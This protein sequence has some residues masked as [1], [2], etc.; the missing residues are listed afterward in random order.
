MAINFT[1]NPEYDFLAGMIPHH[2]AASSMCEVYQN[3]TS[4]G[5]LASSLQRRHEGIC[6]GS[7]SLC[8]NITYG[9]TKWGRYQS[10]FSQRNETEQMLAVLKELGMLDHY[11]SGCGVQTHADSGMFM[12]CGQLQS[13]MAKEYLKLNMWMHTKMS[14]N[15]SGNQAVDFLKGMIPHHEAAVEMCAIYYKYWT[16]KHTQPPTVCR[17]PMASELVANLINQNRFSELDVLNYM[18][19]I[20]T[21]HILVSQ[22]PE[23][24]WMRQELRRIDSDQFAML[25]LERPCSSSS[26]N[27]ADDHSN[28]SHA[29]HDQNG[30]KETANNS[31]HAHSGHTSSIADGGNRSVA[32]SGCMRF[33]S[34]A[35][36]LVALARYAAVWANT[37]WV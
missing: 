20:C 7:A 12:G 30:T 22:P 18:H 23:I 32:V 19:H 31:S 6:C 3:A 11:R 26:S 35:T 13:S 27:Q 36:M 14:L 9:P 21:E 5:S 4:A 15:Y 29:G 10:D 17:N 28:V 24:Q 25:E 16:C 34:R 8:Y 2:Q 33:S 37:I 1:D